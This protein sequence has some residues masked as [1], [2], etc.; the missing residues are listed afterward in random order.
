VLGSLIFLKKGVTITWVYQPVDKA[1]K[2]TPAI[3]AKPREV[4]N[5]KKPWKDLIIPASPLNPDL[6]LQSMINTTK[7][8]KRKMPQL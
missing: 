8:K 7:I 5:S 4:W 6:L 1:K 3:N 2:T